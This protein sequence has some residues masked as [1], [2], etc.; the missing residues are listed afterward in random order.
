MLTFHYVPDGTA[1]ID[2]LTQRLTE[3]LQASKNV[4]WLI[5]GGSNIG[6]SVTVMQSLPAELQTQLTILMT[7]ERYGDFNHPDSNDRQ[8]REAGFQPGQSTYRPML[9]QQNLSLEDT[10]SAYNRQLAE[11]LQDADIVIAQ[12]G[13]GP[14]GHI[15]GMLPRSPAVEGAELYS[16]YDAGTFTRITMTPPALRQVHVAYTFAFGAPKREA[17]QRLQTEELPLEEQP[18]QILKELAEAHLF[19]DQVSEEIAPAPDAVNP[20]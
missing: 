15:A 6:L 9:Q 1:A 5:G 8:L 12:L 10:V 4:L 2:N 13:I 19:S 14:D 18:A 7:D 11:A 20:S 17:L 16:G 3:E